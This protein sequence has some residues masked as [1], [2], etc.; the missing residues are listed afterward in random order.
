MT[1]DANFDYLEYMIGYPITRYPDR[2]IPDINASRFFAVPKDSSKLRGISIEPALKAYVQQGFMISLRAYIR[3]HP[4]LRRRIDFMHP[5]Y[6]ARLAQEGSLSGRFATIDLSDASDSVLWET[7]KAL[8]D[9][10]ALLEAL[11]IARAADINLMDGSRLRLEKF[12]GMGNALTFPL[13]CLI[14]SCIVEQGIR[15]AGG[16]VRKSRYR[17]YGDDIV[18]ETEYFDSVIRR[19][20]LYGFKINYLKSFSGR[21]N[22][23]REA[24]G[25][26]YYE[27]A[28]VKPI[29]LPRGPL[30][31]FDSIRNHRNA[32]AVACF[33]D[34]ANTCYQGLPSVRLFI[35]HELFRVLPV[36]LWPVFTLDGST[37]LRSDTPT[38]FHL[39]K[40]PVPEN[41]V[42]A[43][44]HYSTYLVHGSLSPRRQKV[45]VPEYAQYEY[46]L[47]QL[48][49]RQSEIEQLGLPQ[50]DLKIDL[51]A[52]QTGLRWK[53][54]KTPDY[55]SAFGP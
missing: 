1:D 18:V 3:N 12:G 4:Y 7:V 29:R 52:R 6:S 30:P 9:D 2:S 45:D 47:N 31:T 40:L 21:D 49:L 10:T 33:I 22:S 54:V 13:E 42:L 17:V 23:F 41:S 46:R 8:A 25:G 5:E 26:E 28:D 34:I 14:F 19:L 37:G 32:E 11:T 43:S 53:S 27:G 39:K 50:I 44:W 35:I 24:C 20:E 55:Y 16:S 15:D 51:S 36:N 38:N 48:M